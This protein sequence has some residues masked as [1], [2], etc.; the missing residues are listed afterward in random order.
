[1]Y[2]VDVAGEYMVKTKSWLTGILTMHKL[3]GAAAV[4]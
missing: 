4:Q 1:M 2:V 3:V